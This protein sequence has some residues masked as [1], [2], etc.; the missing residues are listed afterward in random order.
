MAA[1]LAVR[2][3]GRPDAGV[4]KHASADLRVCPFDLED[5]GHNNSLL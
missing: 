3:V 5:D 2:D 1:I 4:C